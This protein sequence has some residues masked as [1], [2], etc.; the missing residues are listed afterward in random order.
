[1][2]ST[3]SPLQRLKEFI[4]QE[5]LSFPDVCQSPERV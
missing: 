4:G 3:A 2:Y 5:V 1:M